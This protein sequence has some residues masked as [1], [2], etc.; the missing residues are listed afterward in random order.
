VSNLSDP[1]VEVSL[2]RKDRKIKVQRTSA[3]KKEQNPKYNETLT[4]D[5][6]AEYLHES[7]LLFCVLSKTTKGSYL[8]KNLGKVL[9]GAD[10][11]GENFDHWEEMRI[12]TKPRPRWH[13][14]RKYF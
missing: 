5:V 2:L 12:G 1:F 9:L 10:G 4:F 13:K 3:K 6:P 7:S 14:L 11:S 8:E